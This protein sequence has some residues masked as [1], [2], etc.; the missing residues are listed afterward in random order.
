MKTKRAFDRKGRSY[1]LQHGMN[2]NDEEFTLKKTSG[3]RDGIPTS[4]STTYELDYSESF[5][6]QR[7]GILLSASHASSY[8]EQYQVA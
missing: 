7:L 3:P 4:G 8:T 6:N 5:L 1:G 2:F